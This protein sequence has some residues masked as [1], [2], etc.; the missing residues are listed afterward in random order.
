MGS[1]LD[2]VIILAGCVHA[3]APQW[4]WVT[5]NPMTAEREQFDCESQ[6]RAVWP[7]FTYHRG[8]FVGYAAAEDFYACCLLS[9][10]PRREPIAAAP[11]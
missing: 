5:P 8:R 3:P 11:Q 6:T 10:G 7:S 2:G 9:R 1:F 4:Q